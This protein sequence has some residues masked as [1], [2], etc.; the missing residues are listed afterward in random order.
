MELKSYSKRQQWLHFCLQLIFLSVGFWVLTL[1]PFGLK[2]NLEDP[3]RWKMISYVTLAGLLGCSYF[4]Y[5]RKSRYSLHWILGSLLVFSVTVATPITLQTDPVRY[6]WDGYNLTQGKNPFALAPQVDPDFSEYAG[7]T[8]LN[9][10][11]LS[12]IY[13][14]F[15]QILFFGSTGLNPYFWE[16]LADSRFPAV[17]TVNSYFKL[18]LGWKLLVGLILSFWVYL[19]RNS[20]WDLFILH[21]LALMTA[22]GNAHI[23]AVL[24][25]LLG[26]MFL[27]VVKKKL[28]LQSFLFGLAVLT[29]WIPVMYL[30]ALV[31]LWRKQWGNRVPIKVV[32][33]T[34]LGIFAV[35]LPF[36]WTAGGNFFVGSEAY[37]RS[38]VFFG[39]L[40]H[41]SSQIL[42]LM[43]WQDPNYLAKYLCLVFGASWWA[44][45]TLQLYRTLISFR[46]YGYLMMLGFLICMPT[47]HPWYLLP[48]VGLALP[49][50]RVFLTPFVWGALQLSSKLVYLNSTEPLVLRH[51]VF[52]IVCWTLWLD[53]KKMVRRWN[54]VRKARL[55]DKEAR[56]SFSV[57]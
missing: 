5:F 1:L 45:W 24:Y 18:G 9:H 12:T 51:G 28:K 11:N 32:L 55:L 23:D 21:P 40:H 20:R 56:Y 16:Y 15:A 29:K 35:V 8:E 3:N 34:V 43:G 27:P 39:F 47:L 37:A 10:P 48:L 22:L 57:Q 30:P 36:Y 38:W 31:L 26:A 54:K 25:V 33:A 2:E 53:G 52:L 50:H 14:P 17:T 19:F 4:F 13:P 46:L 44:F 41:Y 49:Y 6:V 7:R 42:S